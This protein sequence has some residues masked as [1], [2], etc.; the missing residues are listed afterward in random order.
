MIFAN[1]TRKDV[2][3]VPVQWVPVNVWTSRNALVLV[4]AMPGI[5]EENV[6]IRLIDGILTIE[7]DLRTPAPKNYIIHEWDYGSYRREFVVGPCYGE[8]VMMSLGNG[9]LAVSLSTKN[10]QAA[11]DIA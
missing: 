1:R 10:G 7:A 3:D 9:L 5:A 2:H 8:P 4:A 6:T 11:G